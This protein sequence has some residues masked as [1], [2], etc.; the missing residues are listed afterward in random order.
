[1]SNPNDKAKNEGESE[2]EGAESLLDF[3][4]NEETDQDKLREIVKEEKRA[5]I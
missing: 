3:G 4:F 1:M 5:G 2:G